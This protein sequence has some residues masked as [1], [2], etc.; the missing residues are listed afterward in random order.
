[1]KPL[2]LVLAFLTV[3]A[4]AA[5]VGLAGLA[6]VPLVDLFPDAGLMTMLATVLLVLILI[7]AVI[8]GLVSRRAPD[9]GQEGSFMLKLIIWIAVLLGA[10]ATAQALVFVQINVAQTHTTNLKVVAPSLAEALIPLTIGLLAGAIAT[11][12]NRRVRD[13]AM[14]P[15]GRDPS[16]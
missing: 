5:I 12:F 11:G 1:M 2:P 8:I 16:L 15:A 4:G 14:T 7:A 10:L 9:A 6:G 3:A 13:V